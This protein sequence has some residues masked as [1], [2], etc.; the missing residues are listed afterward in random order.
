MD[1]SKIAN[2]LKDNITSLTE[3]LKSVQEVSFDGIWSG[4]AYNNLTSSLKTIVSSGTTQ[5]DL[6]NNLVSALDKLQ[7]YKNNCKKIDSLESSISST[8]TESDRADVYSAISGLKKDNNN[9]KSNINKLLETIT[10]V[11]TN[12]EVIDY[13]VDTDNDYKQYAVDINELYDLFASGSLKKIEYRSDSLYNYYSRDEAHR[14]INSINEQYDGREAAVNCALGVIQMAAS[15]GKKLNYY[16]REN[17]NALLTL[18]DVA[19]YSDCVS[20]ASWALSQ[21]SNK[22]TKTFNTTEFSNLGTKINYADAKQG[23]I[24]TTKYS[25]S[26]GHVMLVVDNSPENGCALVAEAGGRDRGVVLTRIKYSTLE[27]KNYSARDLTDLY[28]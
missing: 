5:K 3:A 25:G 10:G 6:L 26:G 22:V 7:V 4:D 28:N 24:F 20:F 23:D 17:T 9:L 19:N 8:M 16:L 1:Y 14:I 21:G 15:V 18:D 2:N 27:D 12:Y 13:N 11:S